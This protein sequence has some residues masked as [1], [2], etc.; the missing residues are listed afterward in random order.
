MGESELCYRKASTLLAA[1]H[2]TKG[3]P[4][5][6]ARMPQGTDP[7]SHMSLLLVLTLLS[8][9]PANNAGP[10]GCESSAGGYPGQSDS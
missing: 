6:A 9:G 7:S 4:S 5:N 1:E 3:E 10:K 8:R 2:D